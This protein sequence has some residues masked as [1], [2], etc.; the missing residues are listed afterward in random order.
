MKHKFAT[1][2]L[3]TGVVLISSC[4]ANG[5]VPGNNRLVFVNYGGES[6]EA[7]KQGWLEPYS[8]STGTQFVT[9]GPSDLA[10]IR[11]MVESGRTTWDIVDIDTAAG[12]NECGAL[13]AKRPTDFDLAE[14]DSRYV[15]D[16]CM[17]PVMVQAVGVVYN[18]KLYGDNPPT[19]VEDFMNV[20]KFPGKR[21]A[22]NY[23]AGTVEPLLMADGVAPEDVVPVDWR[24]VENAVDRLGSD[25]VPMGQHTQIVAALE[26]G[27][28]GMC[29]CYTGRAA[30]AAENGADIGV[31]WDRVFVATGGLYAVKESQNPEGQWDFLQYL[32]TSDGQNPFYEVLP[33]GPTTTGE[34]PAVTDVYKE[35]MPTFNSERTEVTF[36]YNVPFWT[37]NIDSAMESWTRIT[38]G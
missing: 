26:A 13:F 2:A 27:D 6:L 5:Q 23:P 31:L 21:L 37:E 16:E 28:F 34:P 20:S 12:A 29:L 22:F 4:G 8:S 19:K 38:S 11:T 30:M 1:V 14:I 18:K 36:T 3:M 9:D 7:A 32:A 10:K 15:T 33:Y 24:R 25:F 17:V 35:F